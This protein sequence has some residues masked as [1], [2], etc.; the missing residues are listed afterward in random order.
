MKIRPVGPEQICA[1]GRTD[2]QTEMIKPIVAFRNLANA[3]KNNY[4]IILPSVLYLTSRILSTSFRPQLCM[5]LILPVHDYLNSP[6]L[7]SLK[8]A[9]F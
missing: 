5:Y 7:K 1:D 3:P 9:V 6:V 2:G 8:T 4:K